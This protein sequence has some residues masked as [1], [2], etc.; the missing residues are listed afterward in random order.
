MGLIP[1]FSAAYYWTTLRVTKSKKYISPILGF[2]LK[3]QVNIKKNPNTVF[4][5]YILYLSYYSFE[6]KQLLHW[7]SEPGNVDQKELDNKICLLD[8]EDLKLDSQEEDFWSAYPVY[9]HNNVALKLLKTDRTKYKIL[10]LLTFS[11]NYL[12]SW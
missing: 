4:T 12:L 8:T 11:V 9:M 5:V 7:I 3:I 2:R 10:I 1:V 6:N